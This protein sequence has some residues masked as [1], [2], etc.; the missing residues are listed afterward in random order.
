VTN[1]SFRCRK[2]V[3]EAYAKTNLLDDF[4]GILGI[5]VVLNSLS[6]IFTKIFWGD[7]NKVGDLGL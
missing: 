4:V 1:Q 6:S 3:V 7:L 2:E 5:D